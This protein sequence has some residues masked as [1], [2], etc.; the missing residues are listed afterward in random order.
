M[1][2]KCLNSTDVGTPLE[3]VGCETVTECMSANAFVNISLTGG[4]SNGL[5]DGAGVKIMTSF[6]SLR[7]SRER[8]S[9]GNTY[10]QRQSFEALGYLSASAYG[11]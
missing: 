6:F 5:V 10:C 7:G 9:A 11:K 3:E 1:P 8:L 2:Q 4:S